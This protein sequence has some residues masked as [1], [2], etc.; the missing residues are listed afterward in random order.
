MLIP[1]LDQQR[2]LD[3]AASVAPE[4]LTAEERQR[5]TLGDIIVFSHAPGEAALHSGGQR[6]V[7]H[8]CACSGT[9]AAS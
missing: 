9:R 7:L 4:R 6:L 2:L 5:N 1:F 8:S 3:A